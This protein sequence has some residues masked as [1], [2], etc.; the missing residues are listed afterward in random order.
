MNG[1]KK[2]V[3]TGEYYELAVEAIKRIKKT[4]FMLKG[5][6]CQVFSV[7]SGQG[8]ILNGFHETHYAAIL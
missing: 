3:R 5:R 1:F 7:N 2:G 8:I 6:H 4:N